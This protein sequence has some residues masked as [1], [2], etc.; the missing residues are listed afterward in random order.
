MG[1][2]IPS[3]VFGDV[4]Q[5]KD[6]GRFAIALR[7]QIGAQ[8]SRKGLAVEDSF[9]FLEIRPSTSTSCPDMGRNGFVLGKIEQ[10]S[11]H[12]NELLSVVAS[13][14]AREGGFRFRL[15]GLYR[16]RFHGVYRSLNLGRVNKI[17][18]A[19]LI[20]VWYCQGC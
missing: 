10:G 13:A 6:S 11:L 17:L 5:R 2:E 12:A 16:F 9:A 15:G 7:W 19:Y 4:R 3:T 20:S 1:K 8:L 14:A 18:L